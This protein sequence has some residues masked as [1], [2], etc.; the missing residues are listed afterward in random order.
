MFGM[1]HVRSVDSGWYKGYYTRAAARAN[2]TV[3][4]GLG[5]MLFGIRSQLTIL[6]IMLVSSTRY[7]TLE[8]V[9]AYTHINI[10]YTRIRANLAASPT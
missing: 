7:L 9:S 10:V 1:S 3:S 6:V 8:F 5:L 2:I 4:I